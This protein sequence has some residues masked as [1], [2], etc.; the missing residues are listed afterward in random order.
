MPTTPSGAI[1]GSQLHLPP[2]VLE[3]REVIDRHDDA[4]VDARIDR[5]GRRR[6][7]HRAEDRFFV[8]SEHARAGDRHA[9]LRIDHAFLGQP[10]NVAADDQLVVADRP[11]AGVADPVHALEPLLRARPAIA[12]LHP[13]HRTHVGVAAVTAGQLAHQHRR[14][15]RLE[16]NVELDFGKGYEIQRHMGLA[17]VSPKLIATPHCRGLSRGVIDITSGCV[18]TGSCQSDCR[19]VGSFFDRNGL[20]NPR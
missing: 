20:C 2:D 6:L 18:R 1:G 19:N 11:Q 16:V 5:G 17:D 10:P 12:W 3:V 13:V 15:R 14:Q 7:A 8:Q 4:D 9:R